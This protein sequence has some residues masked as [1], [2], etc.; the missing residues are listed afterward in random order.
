MQDVKLPDTPITDTY[1]GLNNL[2]V[3]FNQMKSFMDD[4]LVLV[5]GD[6][7][8]VRDHTGQWYIDGLAGVAAVQVGHRNQGIIDAMTAQLNRIALT[9]PPLRCLRAG[10]CAGGAAG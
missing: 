4:P 7:V 6:G 10:N 1:P 5:E 2:V 3:D 9:P 8:R